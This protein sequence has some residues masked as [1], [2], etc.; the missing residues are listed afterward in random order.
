MHFNYVLFLLEKPKSPVFM[1]WG[2][3]I[4]FTTSSLPGLK[5]KQGT[6]ISTGK[7]CSNSHKI[8]IPSI[9]EYIK[10]TL[11][12]IGTNYKQKTKL[13]S[14]YILKIYFF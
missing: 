2:T 13:Y 7:K 5:R 1:E 12:F 10:K 6:T 9:T 8:S 3:S 4:F 14:I 11:I